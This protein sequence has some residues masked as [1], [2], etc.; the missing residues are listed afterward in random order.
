MS[1]CQGLLLTT[2][3]AAR[4]PACRAALGETFIAFG[5]AWEQHAGF[6]RSLLRNLAQDL[7]GM[8]GGGTQGGAAQPEEAEGGTEASEPASSRDRLHK[9]LGLSTSVAAIAEAVPAAAEPMLLQQVLDILAKKIQDTAPPL[10]AASVVD[11]LTVAGRLAVPAGKALDAGTASTPAGATMQNPPSAPAA[12]TAAATESADAGRERMAVQLAAISLREGGPSATGGTAPGPPASTPPASTAEGPGTTSSTSPAEQIYLSAAACIESALAL[13]AVVARPA[14][15]APLLL[16]QLQWLR[17]LQR[18]GPPAA[19]DAA[20]AVVMGSGGGA[21]LRLRAHSS[22]A[23]LQPLAQLL[24]FLLQHS[25]TATAQLLADAVQL[26]RGQ[27]EGQGEPAATLIFSL[28]LLHKAL[29]MLPAARAAAAW[30]ALAPE[31]LPSAAL[32]TASP[33]LWLELLMVLQAASALKVKESPG[34]ASKVLQLQA[35]VLSWDGA[36]EAVHLHALRWLQ[37]TAAALPPPAVPHQ[38]DVTSPAEDSRGPSGPLSGRPPG[39]AVRAVL[40]AAMAAAC[41]A[42]ARIREAALHSIAAL[43][44]SRLGSTALL[45]DDAA[46]SQLY[47]LAIVA[48]ADLAPAAAQAAQRLVLAAAGVLALRGSLGPGSSTEAADCP[49]GPAS[50]SGDDWYALALQP[51]QHGFAPQQLRQLMS[52]LLSPGD[53]GAAGATP[54]AQPQAWLPRLLAALPGLPTPASAG[55]YEGPTITRRCGRWVGPL[56]TAMPHRTRCDALD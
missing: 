32:A 46:A 31:A 36:E 21:L 8:A 15:L 22:T 53:E 14:A 18:H 39:T 56:L 48:L 37:A 29:P 12:S 7:A 6:A 3:Q 13:P 17:F 54:E 41:S 52:Y 51:Q 42:S 28:R 9:F 38:G 11:V 4:A 40:L 33:S 26:A 27:Q 34:S 5:P 2:R 16:V 47:Q 19:M 20:A 55:G 43:A 50:L 24:V 35:A 49:P 1:I 44:A 10:D 45:L 25:P 23:L 30:A